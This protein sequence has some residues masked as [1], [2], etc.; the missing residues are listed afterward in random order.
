MLYFL[1]YHELAL[2]GPIACPGLEVNL[3]F[4][5]SQ[6]SADGSLWLSP[7]RVGAGAPSMK[8]VRLC[9]HVNVFAAD[10]V[11]MDDHEGT[12]TLDH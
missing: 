11:L 7:T 12:R 10:Y 6:P 5:L 1:T 4:R 8:V 2:K 9:D 3:L